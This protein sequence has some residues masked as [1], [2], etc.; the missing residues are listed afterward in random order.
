MRTFVI[1]ETGCTHE[2]DLNALLSLVDMA[3]EAGCDALKS[4][5]VSDPA[6]LCRRRNARDY[7]P[8]YEWLKFPAAWHQQLLERC[9]RRGLAYGCTVYLPQDVAVIDPFVSFYKV[10][11]FEAESADLLDIYADLLLA[12]KKRVYVSV[13]M[14]AHWDPAAHFPMNELGD[15]VHAL[16]CVS[17]YP[18]PA[19]QLNLATIRAQGFAGLSDHT[20][21]DNVQT[22]ALA[23]AAGATVIER[24]IRL[25]S[26]RPNNPDYTVAMSLH[27][28][29]EYVKRIRDAELVMGEPDATAAQ[30]AE[31]PMLKFRTKPKT[32]LE[33]PAGGGDSDGASE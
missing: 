29:V 22:G 7:Q 21:P 23:V 30:P 24:H 11:A 14:G 20:A 19:D 5:W 28:L 31:A 18:T 8:Y 27:G 4:Q 15:R 33:R 6:E 10:A 26:C 17:A 1:A 13:A 16:R 2:G 12:N 25:E 9:A 3:A 32:K